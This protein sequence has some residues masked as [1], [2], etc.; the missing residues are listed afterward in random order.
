MERFF[1][2]LVFVVGLVVGT[3]AIDQHANAQEAADDKRSLSELLDAI[4]AYSGANLVFSREELPD[5]KYHDVMKPLPEKQRV[6]A[7]LV[8]FEEVQMYPPGFFGRMGV[9][10]IGVFAAC[11][12]KTSTY[13]LRPYDKGLGGYRYY[14]I[15]NGNNAIA[16][17][18]YNDGQLRMTIHHE[19]FHHVDSTIDGETARWQLSSDDAFYQAAISGRQTYSAPPVAEH[20]LLALKSRC[21][22][23]TLKD[24]VSDYAAK[25]L[26]EDQ[27]E[28][29]RHL[30]S[31]LANSLVQTIE[32][33]ELPGSQRILHVLREYEQAVPDGPAFD[34]FVDVALDRAHQGVA[35]ESSVEC[36]RRLTKLAETDPKQSIDAEAARAALKSIVRLDAKSVTVAEKQLILATSSKIT[37]RLL[38]DRLRPNAT[39]SKFEVWGRE[40]SRGVNRTLR[41]DVYQVGLDAKRLAL[42]Q[43]IH[44]PENA[45]KDDLCEAALIHS[46][47]QLARYLRYIKRHWE[48]TP[49]TKSVFDGAQ[50]MIRLA[51]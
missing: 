4:Q 33:P 41:H 32:Q 47:T 31:M 19:I 43:R 6:E 5:G 16:V 39:G 1:R 38:V 25:N 30:M 40:D 48:I 18:F 13:A 42:I 28:T 22:G 23:I 24:S 26:R 17:A 7:A 14:G 15:Y 9:K 2:L 46:R 20:D 45:A 49:G 27:A 35:H 21:I 37:K 51:E 36:I 8:C 34:W 10:A 12:S 44:D 11:A 29:A 3:I 50:S